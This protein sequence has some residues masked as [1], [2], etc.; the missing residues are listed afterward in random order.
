[1]FEVSHVGFFKISLY[2]LKA[3]SMWPDVMQLF[4][5]EVMKG[6]SLSR[7]S[8]ALWN[9]GMQKQVAY[10]CWCSYFSFVERSLSS[11]HFRELQ[12]N[13]AYSDQHQ[14]V[15]SSTLLASLNPVWL[16]HNT[17]NSQ[18]AGQENFLS[19]EDIGGCWNPQYTTISPAHNSD[20]SGAWNH[21]VYAWDNTLAIYQKTH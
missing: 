19:L 6:G 1:M 4:T 10:V 11:S 3:V 15:I 5:V 2:V 13:K 20:L 18:A 16:L 9:D 12:H 21:G 7:W 14:G 8:T 17:A